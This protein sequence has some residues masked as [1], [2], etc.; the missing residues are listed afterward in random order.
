MAEIN[1]NKRLEEK[2]ERLE[3]EAIGVFNTLISYLVLVGD[4]SKKKSEKM[5][6]INEKVGKVKKWVDEFANTNLPKLYNRETKVAYKQIGERAKSLTS[7]QVLEVNN[8]RLDLIN[9]MNDKLE[10]YNRKARRLVL[11]R[12]REKIRNERLDYENYEE[13]RT[14]NRTKQKKEIV[15]MDSK[16]REITSNAI[17]T[18]VVG[19]A[20][21]NAG[22]SARSAVWLLSG[23]KYGTHR[24]VI[25]SR[26][27]PVCRKLN[28]KRRNL[29]KD[30]LPP[31]HPNCRSHIEPIKPKK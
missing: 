14:I 7:G 24:S 27:T 2:V 8:L 9:S 26:T 18:I 3:K 19:D 15:L 1:E 10:E 16:G 6:M 28:G 22:Y 11:I 20:M 4:S 12:E 17:I 23:I 21:F 29:R 5:K 30:K 25:D 31:M 13:K